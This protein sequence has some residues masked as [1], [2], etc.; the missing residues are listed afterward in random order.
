MTKRR[1]CGLLPAPSFG[2]RAHEAHFSASQHQPTSNPRFSGPE[3]HQRRAAGSQVA[4][5]KR[6]LA[7]DRHDLPKVGVPGAGGFPARQRVRRRSEFQEI[8]AGA[9]RVST[10]HFALLVYARDRPEGASAGPARLGITAS[11]RVGNAVVR[12]RA[13]RL[14][15][16]AFRQTRDL[17][18]P[19]VDLVVIVRQACTSMSCA[20]VISEW[21]NV[22]SLIARRTRETL[23]DR[24]RRARSSGPMPSE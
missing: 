6:A 23:A 16:E 4:P 14:I 1:A 12:N 19:G 17:F 18:A 9:R 5:S 22:S 10:P 7:A 15:R 21:R 24:D 3:W 13:K 20:D 11:R 8:Q 2:G